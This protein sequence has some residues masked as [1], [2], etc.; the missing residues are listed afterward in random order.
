MQYVGTNYRQDI[1]NE[2]KNKLTVNLVEPV[3]APEVIVRHI[4]RERMTRIGQSNIQT[5]RETQKIIL[6]A[7]VTASI[8][9]AASVKLA[10]LEYV[11][12]KSEYEAN[13]DFPIV[14]T[15]S[16]KTQCSNEWRT[17]RERNAKL[18]NHRGQGLYFILGQC[19]QLLQDKMKQDTEWNVVST[20]Y[21]PLTL[22]R[23][24]EKTALVQTEDH[25]LLHVS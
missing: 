4:I 7:A 12:A 19:T 22:Y 11:I 1:G 18:T 10:I 21:D 17:Y 24:I 5:A 23:K 15:D 25:T 2:L 20:S 13:V 3:H 14:T 8:D 16:E 9:E 6:E